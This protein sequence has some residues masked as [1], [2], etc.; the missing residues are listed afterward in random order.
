MTFRYVAL[1]YTNNIDPSQC[2]RGRPAQSDHFSVGV[3]GWWSNP[4]HWKS[5]SNAGPL[6]P[7]IAISENCESIAWKPISINLIFQYYPT[8]EFAF[9]LF[10]LAFR[11]AQFETLKSGLPVWQDSCRCLFAAAKVRNLSSSDSKGTWWS[12]VMAGMSSWWLSASPVGLRKRLWLRSLWGWWMLVTR[13]VSASRCGYSTPHWMASWIACFFSCLKERWLRLKCPWN[14][15]W[16]SG[17]HEG[18]T[19]VGHKTRFTGFKI[20]GWPSTVEKVLNQCL[21]VSILV[22]NLDFCWPFS[23][24]MELNSIPMIMEYNNARKDP[25]IT[26]C[27]H[28]CRL[29]R[30]F[31]GVP[32]SIGTHPRQPPQVELSPVYAQRD[33]TFIEVCVIDVAERIGGFPPKKGDRTPF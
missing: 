10:V 25:K 17:N 4:I 20:V 30:I 24:F 5:K 11:G 16:E 21:A 1:H 22:P 14:L 2:R 29:F 13:W 33:A 7:R 28:F 23:I 8:I 19:S 26:F 31:V 6:N 3:S 32:I 15:V 18:V 12:L 27:H 9:W